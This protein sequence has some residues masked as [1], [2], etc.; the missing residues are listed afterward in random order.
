MV[1]PGNLYLKQKSLNI[2]WSTKFTDHQLLAQLKRD[3]CYCSIAKSGPT[4]CNPLDCSL[5]GFPVL[6]HLLGF[7][8]THFHWV[9]DAIQPS[10]P[11]SPSSL[12]AL[13]LSQSQGLFQWVG[14]SHQAANYW[15]FSF[16]LRPSSEYSGFISF[17][18]DWFGSLTV[19]RTLK[20]LLQH[21]NW[22]HQFFSAQPSLWSNSHICTW[23]LEKP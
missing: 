6:H 20:S 22:K 14:S 17:S 19:Q 18:T 4:F 15:N 21:H 9:S 8:Q 13:N 12:P 16:S 23:L 3:C 5:P 10:H 2:L 7:A 11:L 1:R